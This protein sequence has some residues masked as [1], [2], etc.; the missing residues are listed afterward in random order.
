MKSIGGVLII[1]S[2]SQFQNV[3]LVCLEAYDNFQKRSDTRCSKV[4]QTIIPYPLAPTVLHYAQ[5][6]QLK[7][8]FPCEECL[9]A[10]RERWTAGFYQ[11]AV[12]FNNSLWMIADGSAM[13]LCAS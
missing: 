5:F 13:E 1:L 9:N 11:Q 6:E 2:H 8:D 10:A 12:E 3:V 4:F 7:P